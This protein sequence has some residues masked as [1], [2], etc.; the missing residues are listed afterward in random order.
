MFDRHLAPV[1]NVQ[2]QTARDSQF[3]HGER[4]F[5][6]VLPQ[7]AADHDFRRKV[8]VPCADAVSGTCTEWNVGIGMTFGHV[9]RQEVVRIEVIR[10]GA[11]YPRVPMDLKDA[12][13]YCAVGGNGVL[14]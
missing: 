13:N 11:P 14:I 3:V 1:G 12:H 8:R 7:Y 9:V 5:Q 10:I 6:A 2:Q 4:R